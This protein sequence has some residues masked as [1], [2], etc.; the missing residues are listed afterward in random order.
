MIGGGNVLQGYG[1]ACSSVFTLY[2]KRPKYVF[3]SHYNTF[4]TSIASLDMYF[5]A[6][7]AVSHP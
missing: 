3:L 1:C 6:V 5:Y 2:F 7:Y 4:I